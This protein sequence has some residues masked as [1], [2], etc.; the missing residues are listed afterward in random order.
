MAATPTN[1]QPTILSALCE[2]AGSAGGGVTGLGSGTGS[3]T[4]GGGGGV[5][6]GATTTGGGVGGGGGGGTAALRRS[7][8]VFSRSEIFRSTSSRLRA[9]GCRCRY[10]R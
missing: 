5:T 1:D 4:G 9:L 7:S 8:T 6:T 2:T 10:R 3:T